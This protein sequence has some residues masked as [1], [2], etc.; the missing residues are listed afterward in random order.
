MK[1]GLELRTFI[2][3]LTEE[4][5]LWIELATSVFANTPRPAAHRPLSFI[6]PNI[7]PKKTSSL[8]KIRWYL[9]LPFDQRLQVYEELFHDPI[10]FQMSSSP[11]MVEKDQWAQSTCTQSSFGSASDTLRGNRSC[12]KECIQTSYSIFLLSDVTCKA[13]HADFDDNKPDPRRW[14]RL[15]R[16]DKIYFAPDRLLQ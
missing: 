10:E 14:W 2:L 11:I 4:K 13:Y 16:Q 15:S 5:L 12:P 8:I 7:Q 9:K 1:V 3:L 6:S